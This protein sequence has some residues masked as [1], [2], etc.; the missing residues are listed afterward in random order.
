[1]QLFVSFLQSL[2]IIFLIFVKRAR[3]Y[4]QVPSREFIQKKNKKKKSVPSRG[5]NHKFLSKEE[6]LFYF[7]LF[8]ISTD[9]RFLVRSEER[10][11]GKEC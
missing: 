4:D 11:V 7:Y 10:R 1:M 9:N 2:N 8:L 5:N 3:R 6:L